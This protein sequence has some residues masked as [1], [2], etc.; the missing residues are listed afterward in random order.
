LDS[1]IDLAAVTS[2]LHPGQRRGGNYKTHGGFRFDNSPDNAV[3]VTAP[4]EGFLVRG[5]RYI[6]EG[7]TQYTFDVFNNCGIMYRIGHLREL[8]A[9]LQAIA[10]TWPEPTEN[11][12]SQ[13][14]IPPVFVAA[15]DVLATSVGLLNT[16]NTFF[17]FGVYDYRQ[18]NEASGSPEYQTAH[19]DGKELAFHAVCWLRGWLPPADDAVLAALP[20]ADPVSGS[21]SDYCG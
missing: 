20:P 13:A 17:D 9:N 4:L 1:P 10:D 5:A 15:G 6:V 12:A 3:T 11:S 8:P 21:T 16:Q 19:P 14:I 7:E 18:L 2:I